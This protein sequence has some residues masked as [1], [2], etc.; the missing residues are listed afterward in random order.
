MP[1]LLTTLDAGHA[2]APWG[3]LRMG[4][5]KATHEETPPPLEDADAAKANGCRKCQA[6]G[7]YLSV[8]RSG[9]LSQPPLLSCRRC[10]WSLFVK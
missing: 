8:D 2:G 4:L 7:P 6:V 9:P 3:Q 5:H 10:G 1:G